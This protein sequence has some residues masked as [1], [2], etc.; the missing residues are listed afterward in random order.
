MIMSK[1]GRQT[2]TFLIRVLLC[3]GGIIAVLTSMQL[4]KYPKIELGLLS[5]GI[6]LMASTMLNIMEAWLGADIPTLVEDRLGFDKNV[7]QSGLAKVHPRGADT[8][9]YARLETARSIDMM[10]HT[11]RMLTY[12][13]QHKLRNAIAKRGCRIRILISDYQSKFWEDQHV[14]EGLCP[15]TDVQAELK[16]VV[17]GIKDMIEDLLKAEPRLREGSLEL[18]VFPCVPPCSLLI[19]DKTTLRYTP[20]LPYMHSGEVPCF[21]VA[22]VGSPVLLNQYADTFTRV[23]NKSR[24]LLHVEFGFSEAEAARFGLLNSLFNRNAVPRLGPAGEGEPSASMVEPGGV[25]SSEPPGVTS[26]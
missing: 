15:G 7:H 26:E 19:I 18:R 5:F 14:V 11:A 20:Y 17:R 13:H 9:L 23:W 4:T 21:D 24:V 6:A 8:E 3:A 12:G 1:H 2:H 10:Y 16:D 22:P 25:A